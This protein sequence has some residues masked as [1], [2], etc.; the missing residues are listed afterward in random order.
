MSINKE[1]SMY[2]PQDFI[3]ILGESPKALPNAFAV[4]LYNPKLTTTQ[5]KRS[6]EI[7]LQHLKHQIEIEKETKQ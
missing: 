7:L 5:V 3:N 6:L 4:V 2:I 1:N